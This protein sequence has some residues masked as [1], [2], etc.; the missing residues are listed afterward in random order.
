MDITI[1]KFKVIIPT[2]M[3]FLSALDLNWRIC[4][5]H[6]VHIMAASNPIVGRKNKPINQAK[7]K[8]EIR[9]M[10]IAETLT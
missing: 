2:N 5:K 6:G 3:Y 9:R 7:E 8:G 1:E 4:T 10:G